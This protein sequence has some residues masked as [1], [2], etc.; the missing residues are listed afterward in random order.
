MNKRIWIALP[1]IALFPVKLVRKRSSTLVAADLRAI[2]RIE[3]TVTCNLVV[4]RNTYAP[5]KPYGSPEAT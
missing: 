5:F 3:H 1:L 2:K 4:T